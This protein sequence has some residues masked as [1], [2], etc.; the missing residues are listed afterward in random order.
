M[1]YSIGFDRMRRIALLIFALSFAPLPVFGDSSDLLPVLVISARPVVLIPAPFLG[2]VNEFLTSGFGGDLLLEYRLPFWP[3]WDLGGAVAYDYRQVVIAGDFANAPLQRLSAR[4]DVGYSFGNLTGWHGGPYVGVGKSAGGVQAGEWLWRS[5]S[6]TSVLGGRLAIPIMNRTNAVIQAELLI[7]SNLSASDF[8]LSAGL[9]FDVIRTI[10]GGPIK[11]R[12]LEQQPLF[13]ALSPLYARQP[14]GSIEITNAHDS[15]AADI[16][17]SY[18]IPSA[19]STPFFCAEALRL[20]SGEV[21]TVELFAPL[22]EEAF[23]PREGQEMPGTITVVSEV[24]RKRYEQNFQTI[25]TIHHPNAI[26]WVDSRRVGSFITPRDETTLAF[27]REIVR[28]MPEHSSAAIEEGVGRSLGVVETLASLGFTYAQDPNTPF[29]DIRAGQ[30]VLDTVQ[31]PRQT[32]A[33]RSGDCDDLTVLFCA[34][35]E[36]QGTETA[37]ITVPGHIFP[38]VRVVPERSSLVPRSLLVQ[39]EDVFWLPVEITLL[40]DGFERTVAQGFEQWERHALAGDAELIPTHLA[41]ELYAP[42]RLPD[43]FEA[44]MPG[45]DA[46]LL[47]HLDRTV[48][49]YVRNQIYPAERDLKAKISQQPESSRWPLRLGVLYARHGL[50]TDAEQVFLDL[51][52]SHPGPGVLVNLG[53]LYQLQGRYREALEWLARARDIDA[54]NP[55]IYFS[56]T[57]V[58]N[59]LG[60]RDEAHEAYESLRNLDSELAARIAPATAGG[61]QETGRA[62]RLS[63]PEFPWQE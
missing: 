48:D 54:D 60:Q 36:A 9:S 17:V 51:A 34:L 1:T 44:E 32:L 41:W 45:A 20:G 63:A 23:S 30:P 56:L 27:S 52:V 38:A 43:D 18:F 33:L 19:M 11:L 25:V 42:P 5:A 21:L 37:F 50:F 15:P 16:S 26:D 7:D 22:G 4:L 6:A 31:F 28:A 39:Q 57:Q 12:P 29:S 61:G 35:L 58:Y 14:V 8:S 2:E 10:P 24:R 3:N 13:P 59:A 62:S 53:G 47:D 55:R 49:R 46:L 40:G